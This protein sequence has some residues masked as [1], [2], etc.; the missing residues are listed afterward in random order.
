MEDLLNLAIFTI[1]T[2]Y[3]AE[4]YEHAGQTSLVIKPDQI[5]EVAKLLRD[6]YGFDMLVLETA[7][8]YCPQKKPRFHIVYSLYSTKNNCFFGLRAPL[9]EDDPSLP[10]LEPVFPNANWHEREIWDLF[11][12]KFKGHSD[13]RR[14]MMPFDWQGHPL[15]KDYSLDYEE[16]A[17]SKTKVRIDKKKNYARD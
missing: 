7:V 3:S 1:Q 8:D 5:D 4:K 17:F 11:G 14:I 2:R 6:E 16:P 13:L 10:S 9:N 12:I 15:R